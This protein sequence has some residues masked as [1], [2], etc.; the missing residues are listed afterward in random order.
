M[1]KSTILKVRAFPLSSILMIFACQYFLFEEPFNKLS[2]AFQVEGKICNGIHLPGSSSLA[3]DWIKPFAMNMGE[4]LVPVNPHH[5]SCL[6]R[7]KMGMRVEGDFQD[8]SGLCLNFSYFKNILQGSRT[9]AC[10][11]EDPFKRRTEEGSGHTKFW[12]V[13]FSQLGISGQ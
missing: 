7:M 9:W 4:A 12:N 1:E 10:Y 5:A 3:C 11:T 13:I 8:H 6:P 2:L